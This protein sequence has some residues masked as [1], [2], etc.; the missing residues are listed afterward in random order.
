MFL[1]SVAN[2]QVNDIIIHYRLQ[3]KVVKT[4]LK[5]K[6]MNFAKFKCRTL[7]D[8]HKNKIMGNKTSLTRNFAWTA[9]DRFSNLLIQFVLGIIIARL[10]T[11]AEYGILG[12]L[13]VFINISQ[14]FIDSGLSSALIYNNNLSSKNLS[15]VFVFNFSVSTIIYLLL[16]IGAPLI[17]SF[18][19]LHKLS[20]YLKVSAC[21][22]IINSLIDVPTSVLKIKLDF[23]SLALSNLTSTLAGGFI[24]VY[25]A[26]HNYGIWALIAQLLS[27]NILLMCLLF[28]QSKWKPNIL[29]DIPAFKTLFKY[30]INIFSASCLTK[31]IEEGTSFFIAK[32]LNPFSLGIYSRSLQFAA[33]PTSSV[34]GIITSALFPSLSS[35][36]NDEERFENIFHKVIEYQAAICVPLFMWIA[37]VAEPI[38]R[39]LLTD[40]W[41]AVVPILQILC[42]GRILVPTAYITEQVINA[43]GRSDLFFRQQ[44]IKMLLKFMLIMIFIHLGLMAVAIAE[45]T[46]TVLQFFITNH[47]AK[48]LTPFLSKNQLKHMMPYIISSLISSIAGYILLPLF[49]NLYLQ[50]ILPLL[51][52]ALL[53]LVF[54]SMIYRKSVFNELMSKVVNRKV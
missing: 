21:V 35:I 16:F 27:R 22:L 13:M 43:K 3:F 29:F 17:E 53:Y 19:N 15:T 11:P 2:N 49:A 54:V 48:G 47:F 28:V 24:G 14:V 4:T 38:V 26:Y 45:A 7:V 30:G 41:I 51:A 37:M 8:E 32:I 20:L 44:L 40:R 42:I 9:V 50:I 23:R 52:S 39:L 33:L 46:Y 6:K 31:I 10:V 1:F 18:F 36:K 34:G 25:L 5:T 12:I